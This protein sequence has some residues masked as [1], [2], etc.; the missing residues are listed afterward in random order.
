MDTNA[1]FIHV[2]IKKNPKAYNSY[3][4]ILSF[5]VLCVKLPS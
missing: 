5:T 3:S 4:G 2:F 1:I